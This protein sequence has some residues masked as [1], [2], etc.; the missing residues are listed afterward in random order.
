MKTSMVT[1]LGIRPDQVAASFI[2]ST[3]PGG[4]RRGWQVCTTSAT[5]GG[6]LYKAALPWFE[7]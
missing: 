3:A 7:Y 1:T 5:V 6:R 4:N 2:Y